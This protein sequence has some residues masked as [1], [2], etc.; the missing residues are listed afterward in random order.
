MLSSRSRVGMRWARSFGW[1]HGRRGRRFPLGRQAFTSLPLLS[2]SSSCVG[3]GFNATRCLGLGRPRGSCA[4][5]LVQS[6][7]ALNRG[8]AAL[9]RGHAVAVILSVGASTSSILVTVPI[10]I[11]TYSSI[12]PHN[13]NEDAD[14]E[15]EGP[16]RFQG[17]A[18]EVSQRYIPVTGLPR[19]WL[20]MIHKKRS[21]CNISFIDFREAPTTFPMLEAGNE[22]RN[23]SPRM[24][25]ARPVESQTSGDLGSATAGRPT[26]HRSR[27]VRDPN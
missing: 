10:L 8:H 7:Q 15:P 12:R 26:S 5:L 24:S 17:K 23:I 11:P 20:I 3:A 13:P 14:L 21:P 6:L 22:R 1:G 25:R 4:L 27:S 2:R 19:A 9:S 16:V 18:F